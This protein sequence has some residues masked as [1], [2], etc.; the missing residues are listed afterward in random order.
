MG[1]EQALASGL[2]S[3]FHWTAEQI[4]ALGKWEA[5]QK[6]N[7][8][9]IKTSGLASVWGMFMDEKNLLLSAAG[10]YG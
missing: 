8:E 6:S 3:N 1:I 4:I 2:V 10:L 9:T 5:E 7:A